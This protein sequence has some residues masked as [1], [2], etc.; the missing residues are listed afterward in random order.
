MATD[1]LNLCISLELLEERRRP[2]E[3]EEE[4]GWD[5][6]LWTVVSAV[7]APS[8]IVRGLSSCGDREI[9]CRGNGL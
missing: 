5:P 6:N 3:P 4:L 9:Y 8:S 1:F 7:T 2:G